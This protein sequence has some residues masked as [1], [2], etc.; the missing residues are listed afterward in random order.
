MLLDH[1][2]SQGVPRLEDLVTLSAL[3]DN[4]GNMGLD[5]LLHLGLKSFS[6]DHRDSAD[7]DCDHRVLELVGVVALGAAPG[8]LALLLVEVGDEQH[9]DLSLK[10][11]VVRSSLPRSSR[12]LH[13]RLTHLVELD[14]S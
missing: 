12:F 6:N 9:P 2:R 5:V 1:V 11:L 4:T 3:V 10:F 13:H 8:G 7:V 14:L